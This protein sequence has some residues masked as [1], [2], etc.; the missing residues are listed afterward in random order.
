M[1]FIFY[2]RTITFKLQNIP[3]RTEKK[4]LSHVRFIAFDWSL[5][6]LHFWEFE[7]MSL[8]AIAMI[9]QNARPTS[10]ERAR[11]NLFIDEEHTIDC[12]FASLERTLK[13]RLGLTNCLKGHDQKF[14]FSA[15][16]NRTRQN[17]EPSYGQPSIE[18]V[19]RL[20]IRNN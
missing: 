19:R 11:T 15:T 20:R 9:K 3:P 13:Q 14:D 6:P 4:I 16:Y 1:N 10:G 18:V 12:V 17:E 7:N 2:Y 5:C 8:R